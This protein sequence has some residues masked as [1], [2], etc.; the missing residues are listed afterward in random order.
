M[1]IQLHK[2]KQLEQA[3]ACNEVFVSEEQNGQKD[4]NAEKRRNT[5]T[6]NKYN[7]EHF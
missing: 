2:M 1:I 5:N 7:Q 6:Q 3:A 4:K